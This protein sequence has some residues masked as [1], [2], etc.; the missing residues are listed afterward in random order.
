MESPESSLS[1]AIK[2][3]PII[4]WCVPSLLGFLL[5]LFSFPI[6][7]ILGWPQVNVAEV[8]FFWFL[9][10][11]PIGVVAASL[12]LIRARRRG[13]FTAPVSALAWT[14]VTV[15]ASANVFMLLGMWAS[16]Y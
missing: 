2:V 14:L 13:I 6:D 15:S 3:R 1:G 11:A 10:I 12:K 8:F 4:L 5:F 9:T 16:T 7:H